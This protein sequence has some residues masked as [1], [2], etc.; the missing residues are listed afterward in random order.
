MIASNSQVGEFEVGDW[1]L[2]G[3][4]NGGTW[5][6]RTGGACRSVGGGGDICF[7]VY[8]LRTRDKAF[9]RRLG[10]AGKAWKESTGGCRCLA[11]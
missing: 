11:G 2:I 1:I 5:S 8:R 6:R 7:V 9:S 4:P 3:D 10:W